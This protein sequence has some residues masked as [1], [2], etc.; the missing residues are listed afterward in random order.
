MASLNLGDEELWSPDHVECLAGMESRCLS[1]VGI[2]LSVS[3]GSQLSDTHV[4]QVDCEG[5]P[6]Q[7]LVEQGK[8]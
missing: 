1:P 6:A 3:T 7:T 8:D 2:L 5:Q 4:G